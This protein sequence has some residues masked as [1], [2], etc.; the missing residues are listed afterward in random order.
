MSNTLKNYFYLRGQRPRK[1]KNGFSST[2]PPLHSQSIVLIKY[3]TLK[4]PKKHCIV[5]VFVLHGINIPNCITCIHCKSKHCYLIFNLYIE[6]CIFRLKVLFMDGIRWPLFLFTL[7][8]WYNYNQ[9][10]SLR[11]LLADYN[12]CLNLSFTFYFGNTSMYMSVTVW[13]D[14][15]IY[16][17]FGN[18]R[19]LLAIFRKAKIL[20]F[21]HIK[22]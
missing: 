1:T 19:R 8:T 11:C 22:Q 5:E 7:N 6:L 12:R 20:I 3:L 21:D 2:P 16:H 18:F 9:S 13:P 10:Y 14:V 17:H 4:E 15:A